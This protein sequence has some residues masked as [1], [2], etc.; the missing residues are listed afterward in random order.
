MSNKLVDPWG[1]LMYARNAEL[2]H[3]PNNVASTGQI[4]VPNFLMNIDSMS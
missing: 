4:S 3:R 2:N 1:L